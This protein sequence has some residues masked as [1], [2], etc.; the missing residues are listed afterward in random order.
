MAEAL[1]QREVFGECLCDL[2]EEFPSVLCLDGDLGTS[3][4]ADML[5][6]RHPDRFLQM[7]I[8][9]QNMFGVAAGLAT[10]GF[11]PFISTFACFA[12][13][14]AIDQVRVSIAQPKL[15]VK[16]TGAY[17]GI[18]TGKTGKTHQSVEDIAVIRAMPN[19]TL[20]V[21]ADGVELRQMMRA[22]VLT[23]GPMYLRLTRDPFPTIFDD[24][25]RFEIG[26]ATVLRDGYDV[27]IISTGV[28][29]VRALQAAEDILVHEGISALVL[30]VPTVKPLDEDAIVRA[31]D[32]TGVVVTAEDHSVIGGLGGAVAEIL[33]ERHPTIVKRLG[34]MD[35][36]GESAAN[37]DILEKYGLTPSHVAQAVRDALKAARG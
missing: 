11:T 4:R 3:T 29:S 22:A 20:L 30:H 33:S 36:F 10:M 16:I 9:E 35:V 12:A 6:A 32:R 18:L 25:Y 31:A 1:A 8:A 19:M 21:P 26:K 5:A 27:T 2:A 15:N 24:G 34:L 13:K 37:A 14:R 7:G 17:S 23:P 28:Q